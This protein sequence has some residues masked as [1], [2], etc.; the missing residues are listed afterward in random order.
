MKKIQL[1]LI[2]IL[3]VLFTFSCSGKDNKEVEHISEEEREILNTATYKLFPQQVPVIDIVGEASG[4]YR[5]KEDWTKITWP[6]D[7]TISGFSGILQGKTSKKNNCIYMTNLTFTNFSLNNNLFF[8]GKLKIVDDNTCYEK[9]NNG[10]VYYFTKDI[11][12]KLKL[13]GD[14]SCEL[15]FDNL[16]ISVARNIFYGFLVLATTK[17]KV[18]IKK[19]DFSIGVTEL[20]EALVKSYICDG[21]PSGNCW[22]DTD[23]GNEDY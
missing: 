5:Y 20:F 6:F 4:L 13:S 17:G 19:G 23:Y 3:F 10:T 11:N 7:T 8:D 2:A 14:L 9:P 18:E 12:G 15:M 1:F 22:V 16:K 21:D